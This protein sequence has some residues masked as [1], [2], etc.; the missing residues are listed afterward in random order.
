MSHDVAARIA[1]QGQTRGYRRHW[2]EQTLLY[3]IV[4]QHRALRARGRKRFKL[5]PV[6]R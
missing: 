4:E 3:R 2:P 5:L 6:A 1:E